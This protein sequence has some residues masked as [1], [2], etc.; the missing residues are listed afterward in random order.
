MKLLPF[1]SAALIALGAATIGAAAQEI[2]LRFIHYQSGNQPALRAILDEF[3]AAHPGITVTD[4]PTQGARNVVSEI[5]AAAA[6]DRPFDI[7]QVLAR[8]ALGVIEIANAQPFSLC[9]DKGAFMDNIAENLVDVANG[10]TP[11]L[12]TLWRGRR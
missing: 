4:L 7:G 3:E 2:D 9:P 5:Q 12:G 1:A 6:A 8:T 10:L 11:T